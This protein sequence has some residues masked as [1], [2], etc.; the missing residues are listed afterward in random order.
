MRRDVCGRTGV[1]VCFYLFLGGGIFLGKVV[2]KRA[3]GRDSLKNCRDSSFF[4][5]VAVLQVTTAVLH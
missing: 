4:L 1:N 3:T 2:T 5:F